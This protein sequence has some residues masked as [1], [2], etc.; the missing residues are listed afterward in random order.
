[1]SEEEKPKVLDEEKVEEADESVEAPDEEQETEAAEEV[2]EEAAE[3]PEEEAPAEEE[4]EEPHYEDAVNKGDFI[5]LEMTGVA[6]TGE[7]IETT[8]EEVATEEGI[9][10][11]EKT[12][13]ARL[14]IVG[15][16]FVLRGLDQKLPGTPWDTEVEVEIPPG[17]AFGER[18][19]NNVETISYR[20]LRSKGVNPM[21][22]AE[23]EID[24]RPAVIRSAGAG[25]VTVDYNH[26]MAGRKITYTLKAVEH[27]TE[28]EDKIKALISR[29][30]LGI[31]PEEFKLDLTEEKLTIKI[32]DQIFYREL[33]E[34]S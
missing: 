6:E 5:K 10:D 27:I 16:G 7:I 11:P 26:P 17:D 14:V 13:G 30:F 3:E 8:S 28:D 1:M 18:D 19:P 15:Q 24:G 34:R 33:V 22:G 20:I 25:R 31:D 21:V 29:R 9:H 2:A 23:L 4:P 12:Y 32:P